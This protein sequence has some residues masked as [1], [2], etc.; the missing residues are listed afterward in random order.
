M[1]DAAMGVKHL[2][3]PAHVGAFE[4]LGEVHKQPDRRYRILEGMRLVPNLDRKT[5]AAHP[6]LVDAQFAIIALALL[7]VQLRPRPRPLAIRAGDRRSLIRL[8]HIGT[9]PREGPFATITTR[10][11]GGN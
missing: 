5:Q 11:F 4:L 6:D 9:L 8:E 1:N 3:E 2:D 7:I 10:L